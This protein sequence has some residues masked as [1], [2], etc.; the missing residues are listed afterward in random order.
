MQTWPARRNPAATQRGAARSRSASSQTIVAE[1]LPSSRAIG[2]RPTERCSSR[3]TAVLPVNEKKRMSWF[4]TSQRPTSAPGPWTSA[5]MS[6]AAGRPASSSST[7]SAALNGVACGG[8]ID[9]GISG[10]ERRRQLVRHHVQRRVERGD[11]AD[12]AARHTDGEG[13]AVRVPGR[14]L[15]RHHLA[16]QPFRFLGGE[17]ERLN[18]AADLVVGVGYRETGLG[19]DAIDEI[20]A[21]AL[22]SSAAVSWRIW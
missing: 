15:D 8:L 11:A 17:Q 22:R 18:R 9:D 16:R 14:V 4:S 1:M 21:A 2:R 20:L 19:D 12:D 5:D 3:P 13:E 6:A 10:G 7:S